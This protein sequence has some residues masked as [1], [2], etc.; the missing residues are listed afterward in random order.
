[1]QHAVDVWAQTTHLPRSLV[2][3]GA[4]VR[5]GERLRAGGATPEQL[6]AWLSQEL[7]RA[8]LAFAP[9]GARHDDG[10]RY[11]LPFDPRVPRL[12]SQ[13]PGGAQTHQGRDREAFDFV[14]PTGTPVLA[15]REGVVARVVDGFSRGGLDPALRDNHVL[16][17]HADGSFA[18]YGHLSPGVPVRVGQRVERGER[19]ARSGHTGYA[20]A[21]HLHFAVARVEPGGVE[22]VT[23]PVRFGEPGGPGFVPRRNDFVGKAPVPNVTLAVAVAGRET[24]PGDVVAVRRGDE[25]PIRVTLAG[26][27]RDL[28]GDVRLA[29]VS[30][31]PWNLTP[32]RG[33]VAIEPMP[34]FPWD[35]V[36]GLTDVAVLGV[37]WDDPARG[38]IGLGQ[39]QFQVQRAPAP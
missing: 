39:V 1:V 18:M 29:L 30:M 21:P 33:A 28:V 23:L 14:M 19:I 13:G 24:A 25:L 35:L 7:A 32:S 38:Q 34:G 27:S 36:P 31:T 22:Q 12:L 17:L 8:E 5:E 9:P 2:D 4:L 15:A 37:Y 16:V 10:V 3:V 6:T 11:A 26:A 20:V